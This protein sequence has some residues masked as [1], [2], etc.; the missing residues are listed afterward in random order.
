MYNK[1]VGNKGQ[2]IDS[3]FMYSIYDFYV[4]SVNESGLGRGDT[5]GRLATLVTLEYVLGRWHG[6]T[7]STSKIRHRFYVETYGMYVDSWC[8]CVYSGKLRLC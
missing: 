2:E 5:D 7:G 3:K 4:F 6:E 1:S 8:A